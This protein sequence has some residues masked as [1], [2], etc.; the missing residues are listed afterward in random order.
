MPTITAE[1]RPRTRRILLDLSDPYCYRIRV[2]RET[3]TEGADGGVI[4]RTALRDIIREI[5]FDADGTPHGDPLILAL[6]PDIRTAVEALEA[7]DIAAE[8]PAPE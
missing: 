2:A 3:V 8:Q 4:G 7:A 6:L 5:T 1:Q